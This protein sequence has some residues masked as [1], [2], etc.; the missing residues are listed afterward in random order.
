MDNTLSF[1]DWLPVE[2]KQELAKKAKEA[3][4][5]R[6][7]KRETLAERTGI[8]VPTIKRYETT[9]EISLHQF[10]KIVFVL[11][12]LNKLKTVFDSEAPFY[13]S[14][15]DIIKEKPKKTRKR[16]SL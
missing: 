3:R 13:A 15:E 2:A 9:G 14:L 5:A 4:L 10:L 7:W 6:S 8:P 11:G 1:D 12:D 16:G